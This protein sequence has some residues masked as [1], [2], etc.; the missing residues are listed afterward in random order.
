MSPLIRT[1]CTSEKDLSSNLVL[2]VTIDNL[3]VSFRILLYI[4]HVLTLESL[5]KIINALIHM[6]ILKQKLLYIF[7]FSWAAELSHFKAEHYS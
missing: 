7:Y 3:A 5:W 6:Q 4:L 1:L 2:Y